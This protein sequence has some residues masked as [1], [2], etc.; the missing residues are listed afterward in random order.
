MFVEVLVKMEILL[1]YSGKFK[2]NE[3]VL[4]HIQVEDFHTDI[5]IIELFKSIGN[6]ICD[7]C[8]LR[9]VNIPDSSS[10]SI[11][12]DEEKQSEFISYSTVLYPK[13]SKAS[14][15]ELDNLSDFIIYLS[16]KFPELENFNLLDEFEH[17]R[18][19]SLSKEEQ[20]KQ[21]ILDYLNNVNRM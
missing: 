2:L 19:N 16:N 20:D 14:S 12:F 13:F 3:K 11:S 4:N 1:S 10:F 9:I 21:Q 8:K 18:L 5:R 17:F 6:K 15:S 7:N